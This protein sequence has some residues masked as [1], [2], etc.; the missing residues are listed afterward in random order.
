MS[1]FH[2]AAMVTSA[3]ALASLAIPAYWLADREPPGQF[4]NG[5]RVFVKEVAEGAFIERNALN[6]F[7]FCFFNR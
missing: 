2:C 3:L 1:K 6:G 4:I 5:H 7:L